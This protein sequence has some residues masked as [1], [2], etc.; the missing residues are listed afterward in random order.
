LT[1]P[2]NFRK[3]QR[4]AV[5]DDLIYPVAGFLLF[6]Q[7]AIFIV[8]YFITA[9]RNIKIL[10][11]SIYSIVLFPLLYFI[12]TFY[13]D[14]NEFDKQDLHRLEN[15]YYYG[16]YSN[17]VIFIVIPIIFSILL[18]NSVNLYLNNESITYV[19]ENL[20]FQALANFV[21]TPTDEFP[22]VNSSTFFTFILL[23]ITQF[24]YVCVL[25]SF[26]A[27]EFKFYQAEE[28]FEKSKNLGS[29]TKIARKI[30][31]FIKGLDYYDKYIRMNFKHQI[32]KDKIT[33]KLMADSKFNPDTKIEELWQAFQSSDK[34]LPLKTMSELF[35]D[36][37]ADELV[38]RLS[39]FDLFKE[40]IKALMAGIPVIVG[41]ASFILG[42]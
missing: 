25:P 39:K 17:L 31:L 14:K 18:L 42:R 15:V 16:L 20:K 40:S 29:N 32:D 5:D 10:F 22:G 38:H 1:R 33:S 6:I 34:L 2:R 11:V 12:F 7:I 27:R 21:I 37:K 41:V 9:E 13:F 28:Y 3:K 4:D 35:N 23:L 24:A 30:S 8:L 19:M 36:L 26:V